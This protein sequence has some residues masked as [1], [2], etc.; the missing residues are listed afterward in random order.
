MT[1]PLDD[2]LGRIAYAAYGETTG[3]KNYAGLPMPDWEDLGDRIQ[4]AWINAAAGVIAADA[5][6]ETPPA[7]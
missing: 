6:P 5:E 2:R 7:T 1:N 4:Q 3:H